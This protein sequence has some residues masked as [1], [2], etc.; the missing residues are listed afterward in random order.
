MRNGNFVCIKPVEMSKNLL[1]VL[2]VAIVGVSC[3]KSG[4]RTC[5]Y[6]QVAIV[7][8][9]A[10]QDSLKAYLD[11][12]HIQATLHP[13]GFYYKITNPGTGTDTMLLCSEILIDYRGQFKNGQEFDKGTDVY[14]VLGALI[15]GWKKGLPLIKKGGEITLYIPP[16]LGYGSQD[17]KNADNVVVIP[18]NSILIFNIKLKDYTQGY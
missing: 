1:F 4:E 2:C 10:E 12:N 7:A 17:Y 5:A 3:L 6:P 18:G 11:S 9:Q 16:S 15:E 13:A 14:F 8:P